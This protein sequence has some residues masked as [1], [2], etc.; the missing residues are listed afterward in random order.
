VVEVVQEVIED[1]YVI[2]MGVLV[3]EQH[4]TVEMD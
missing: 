1:L 3:V 4:M 2:V